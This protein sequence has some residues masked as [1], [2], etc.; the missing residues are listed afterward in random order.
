MKTNCWSIFSVRGSLEL[1][2]LTS[3]PAEWIKFRRI[4]QLS[5]IFSLFIQRGWIDLVGLSFFT[6]KS[7]LFE[8]V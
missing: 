1:L 8:V 7:S 3:R 5:D 6:K 2:V 4:G